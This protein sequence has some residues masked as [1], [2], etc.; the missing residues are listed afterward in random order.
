MSKRWGVSPR[1]SGKR[2][3][4]LAQMLDQELLGGVVSP[5]K[6]LRCCFARHEDYLSSSDSGTVS[7]DGEPRAERGAI[8]LAR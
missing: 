4:S 2:W 6:A 3:D 5:C 1:Y 7:P 8:G